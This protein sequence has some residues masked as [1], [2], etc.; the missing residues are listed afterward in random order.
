MKLL[1]MGIVFDLDMFVQSLYQL[2]TGLQASGY[3]GRGNSRGKGVKVLDRGVGGMG[4]YINETKG[5]A[6]L[7]L[8][9]LV[10]QC[11]TEK[12]IYKLVDRTTEYKSGLRI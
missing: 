12:Q 7:D 9:F 8:Y 1:Y 2:V 5:L 10:C 4:G 11:R 6:R 3:T